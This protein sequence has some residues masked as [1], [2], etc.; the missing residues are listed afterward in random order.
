MSDPKPKPDEE[1]HEDDPA[2]AGDFDPREASQR[3]TG[4]EE[5]FVFLPKPK[6]K[7]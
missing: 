2:P 4:T 3:F 7:H 6:P 5:D 1:P